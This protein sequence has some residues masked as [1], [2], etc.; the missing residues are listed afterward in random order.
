M[1]VGI[2][3]MVHTGVSVSGYTGYGPYRGECQWVYWVWS[4][5]GWVSVGILGMVHTGVSVSGY[6]GYG[7]YRGECQWV[8]WVWSIQG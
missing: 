4:I 3:G 8:Y 7:P 1:S 6:T 5:Q 2:L